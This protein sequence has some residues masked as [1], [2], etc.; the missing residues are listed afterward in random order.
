MILFRAGEPLRFMSMGRSLEVR[1]CVAQ[2]SNR[3]HRDG[4]AY[5]GCR[6]STHGSAFVFPSSFGG[7]VLDFNGGDDFVYSADISGDDEPFFGIRWDDF[8]GLCQ[9]V[10]LNQDDDVACMESDLMNDLASAFEDFVVA[11]LAGGVA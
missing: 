5:R 4:S 7:G 2:W 3:K 8:W 6:V 11:R 9:A 10:G 1:L